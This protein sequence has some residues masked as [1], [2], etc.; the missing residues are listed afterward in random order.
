ML[1]IAFFLLLAVTAS[2]RADLTLVQKVDAAGTTGEMTI[3]FKGDKVRIDPAPE[4]SMI[5]DSKT[6]DTVTLMHGEKKAMRISGEKMKAAA[7]MVKKF[8]AASPGE[9]KAKLTPLGRKETVNGTATDVFTADTS[10]GKATY[11]I[12]MNYP[13]GAAII[14]EMKTAQPSV[15]ANSGTNIPDFRDL[16][17]VP[18]KIE[19][20]TARGH[21]VMTLI[22]A[23]RDPIPDSVFNVPANY[24]DMK[25][26]DL[27]G[28][29]K[30]PENPA[31]P[32][33]PGS[34]PTVPVPSV[35]P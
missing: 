27:F 11:Y 2:I 8:T 14:Q 7:E 30:V 16:P 17:G 21:V 10:V 34:P 23:K 29:K 3:K 33:V 26:P 15:L 13:D 9:Q 24:T 4:L 12:A 32:R 18:V 6:G 31:G 1:R 5:T 25:M 35:T 28:G 22:S 20:D 19:M